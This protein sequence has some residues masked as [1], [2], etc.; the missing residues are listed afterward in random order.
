VRLARPGRQ[1]D[2]RLRLRFGIDSDGLLWL[3]G[4]DLQ[5][6]GVEPAIGP[7]RLGPVR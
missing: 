5:A 6:G 3:E 2:D 7:L 1:G 4:E